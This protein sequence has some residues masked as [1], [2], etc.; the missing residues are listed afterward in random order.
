MAEWHIQARAGC[1]DLYVRGDYC[2]AAANSSPHWLSEHWVNACATVLH[3]AINADERPFAIR[4]GGAIEQLYQIGHE[5]LTIAPASNNGRKS[6]T[7]RPAK[8]LR[9]TAMPTAPTTGRGAAAPSSEQTTS[10]KVM[11]LR[12]SIIPFSQVG[13][14]TGN[15]RLGS[16]PQ[17]H[18]PGHRG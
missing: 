3:F 5:L 15:A 6:S 1:S 11:I 16:K 12:M 4:Q 2:L 17:S 9:I 8:G 13:A 10:R 14:G 7:Y 18:G